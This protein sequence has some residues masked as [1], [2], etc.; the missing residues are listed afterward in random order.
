MNLK[1][2]TFCLTDINFELSLQMSIKKNYRYHSLIF[3]LVNFNIV[4]CS[5]LYF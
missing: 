2:V 1:F 5:L 4:C 3:V